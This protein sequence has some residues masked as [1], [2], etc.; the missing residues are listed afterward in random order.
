MILSNVATPP[1][2]CI[3]MHRATNP[4]VRGMKSMS[5]QT[6]NSLQIVPRAARLVVY[7]QRLRSDLCKLPSTPLSSCQI[8]CSE[9]MACDRFVKC[10]WLVL[11][12]F[13]Q[14]DETRAQAHAHTHDRA[15]PCTF[16]QDI[17]KEQP[18]SHHLTW[19]R[20][21]GCHYIKTLQFHLP[22]TLTLLQKFSPD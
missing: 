16:L 3:P 17:G 12:N 9:R 18:A 10:Q 5:F 13:E 22:S 11:A 19:H 4:G 2:E 8:A 15:C 21:R 20:M 14:W 1:V 6:F 7:W